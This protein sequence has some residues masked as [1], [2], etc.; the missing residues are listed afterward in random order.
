MTINWYVFPEPS[1]SFAAAAAGC[2]QATGGKYVIKLNSLSTSSDQ[3]RISLVRRLAAKDSP[4]DILA[5]DI[6]WSAESAA[7]KWI[8]PWTGADRATVSN[9]VLPGPPQTA[10]WNGKLYAAPINSNT[11]LLWYRNDLVPTRP[12]PGRR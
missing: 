1:G 5:M 3:Q 4:I 6:D 12:R 10:T 9:G 8:L 7:A 2:S 11:A